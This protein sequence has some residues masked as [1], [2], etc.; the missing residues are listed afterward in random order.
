MDSAGY[1]LA[2]TVA[3]FTERKHF[4]STEVLWRLVNI[5]KEGGAREPGK[6]G[7]GEREAEERFKEIVLKDLFLY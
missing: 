6:I 2:L 5:A 7:A 1:G 4:A 3:I